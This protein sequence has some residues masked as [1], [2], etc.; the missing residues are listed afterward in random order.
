M[1]GWEFEPEF[2]IGNDTEFYKIIADLKNKFPDFIK[3]ID[4]VNIVK[5]H[6]SVYSLIS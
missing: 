5:E 2:E 6:K 3:K 1:G 4:I